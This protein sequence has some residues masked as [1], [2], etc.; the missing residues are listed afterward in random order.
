MHGMINY[1][2]QELKNSEDV[3][4][5]EGGGVKT[6]TNIRRWETESLGLGE[7]ARNIFFPS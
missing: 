6:P 5:S 3:G 1:G 4:T 7:H 2:S